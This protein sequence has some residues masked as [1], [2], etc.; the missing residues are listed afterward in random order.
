MKR[1]FFRNIMSLLLLISG[2]FLNAQHDTAEFLRKTD[3]VLKTK[4]TTYQELDRVFSPY[5]K[6]S[7]LLT[8]LVRRSDSIQYFDG[9][10]YA[11]NQLG[12]RSR[13]LANHSQAIRYHQQGL[14]AALVANN[15]E[16]RIQ[17][18]NMLGLDYLQSNAIKSALDYS[19]EALYLARSVKDPSPL[20]KSTMNAS[21]NGIGNIYRTLEQYDLAIDLFREA[22]ELELELGN[23]PQAAVNYARIGESLEAMGNLEEALVNYNEALELNELV[24]SDLVQVMGNFGIAH[25]YVHQDKL[26]EALGIFNSIL[27]LAEETGDMEMIS[28][29]YINIG[30][31]YIHMDQHEAAKQYL[32]KGLRMA[33]D[34]DIYGNIYTAKTFLHDLYE[35]VEDYENA[36]E[37]YE[38]AQTMRRKISNDR[39]TRYVYDMISLAES[40]DRNNRIESLAQ[41]NELVKLRLKRNQNTL[42]ISTLVLALFILILYIFY[43]QYQLKSDKKLLTL[44]QTMLRSQMNPHFLFNSLNSIKLYIINNE[45]KNAVHYLNKF[46]KLVRKI[47]DASSVKE[48]SLAEELETVKLYM[49]IE[50]IRFNNEINFTVRIDQQIDPHQVKVPSLI[51]Q[52]FLENALWHGLSSKEGEKNIELYISRENERFMQIAITDNGVGRDASEALKKGRILKRKSLGIDI[53]KERLQNFS[54]AYRNSFEID[55]IDLFDRMRQPTGTQI[56]LHIPTA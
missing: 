56:V 42:I 44:E 25:V 27:P 17:S 43:R 41:E 13:N 34:Y 33:E 37:Y 15:L 49:N 26:E 39:N 38:Q 11:Y 28:A 6:D 5:Q 24:S 12:I 55:I 48:I 31:T 46:S 30:W 53:T 50:N 52:P 16:L 54:K 45:K 7:L 3:S 40:E 51:L 8:Y 9:L 10:A 23:I 47:L 22:V 1:S 35:K 36:L 20:I 21:L 14:E 29:I 19:K 18:L 4:P 32:G 2:V